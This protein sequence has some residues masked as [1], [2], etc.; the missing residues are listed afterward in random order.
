MTKRIG[1][2]FVLI[3]VIFLSSCSPFGRESYQINTFP[4]DGKY[5]R[6][7]GSNGQKICY[8]SYDIDQE[9]KII[10]D[11]IEI[12]E[13][14]FRT[15][16]QKQ[17]CSLPSKNLFFADFL[18][19]IIGVSYNQIEEP[20]LFYQSLDKGIS[21]I[22]SVYYNQE[23]LL[24][25]QESGDYP[26]FQAFFS[27]PNF[28]IRFKYL[29]L[30]YPLGTDKMKLVVDSIE[31]GHLKTFEMPKVDFSWYETNNYI[32]FF[33]Q[34]NSQQHDLYRLDKCKMIFTRIGEYKDGSIIGVDFAGDYILINDK[35]KETIEIVN[36]KGVLGSIPCVFPQQN[37]NFAVSKVV[38]DYYSIFV[39]LRTTTDGIDKKVPWIRYYPKKNKIVRKEI[40]LPEEY[41]IYASK[42]YERKND[43]FISI[44]LS[45]K[46]RDMSLLFFYFSKGKISFNTL[47]HKI[48]PNMTI[49]QFTYLPGYYFTWSEYTKME[50]F[51][52]FNYQVYYC[53]L[54]RLKPV[55]DLFNQNP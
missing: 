33:S 2:I 50:K 40:S 38:E 19:T 34:E 27:K 9:Y 7:V 26:L 37:I 54:N 11:K 25:S 43:E 23:N 3:M 22:F 41:E 14:D 17:V 46:S 29:I 20:I 8:F 39:L 31:N 30:A 18:K 32:W 42:Y 51:S 13:Y 10:Q 5:I 53:S 28:R 4:I 55:S 21:K 47:Q 16:E 49:K 24:Y 45:R 44:G 15:L 12:V 6:I 35:G 52:D 1:S 36:P 48:D